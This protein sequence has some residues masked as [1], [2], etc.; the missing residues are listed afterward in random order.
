[1]MT[2]IMVD[3]RRPGQSGWFPCKKNQRVRVSGIKGGR[4]KLKMRELEGLQTEQE[5]EEDKI[6]TIPDTTA[7]VQAVVL[8]APEGMRLFVDLIPG[9]K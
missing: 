9:A 2:A 7:M 1:M 6:I 3:A 4:M 8:D 5:I